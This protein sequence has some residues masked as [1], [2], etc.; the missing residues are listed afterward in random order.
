MPRVEVEAHVGWLEWELHYDGEGA[1]LKRFASNPVVRLNG[2]LRVSV[3]PQRRRWRG[4][5]VELSVQS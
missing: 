1:R 2:V 4:V 3:T 5:H